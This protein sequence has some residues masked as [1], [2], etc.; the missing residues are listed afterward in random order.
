MIMEDEKSN[1]LSPGSWRPKDTGGGILGARG[2]PVNQKHRCPRAG[3]DRGS[4]RE[5]MD[6]VLL[7]LSML[8][9]ALVTPT[10]MGSMVY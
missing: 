5:S 3:E 10:H 4:G 8:F 7:S 6:L 9:R 1:S 2:R